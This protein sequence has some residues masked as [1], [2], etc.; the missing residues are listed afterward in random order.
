MC[1]MKEQI[2]SLIKSPTALEALY[3]QDPIAFEKAFR[4]FALDSNISPLVDF[5]M[6]RF[7]YQE[8]DAVDKHTK[9][10]L[11]NYF[12]LLFLMGAVAVGWVFLKIPDFTSINDATFMMRN[13][14]LSVLPAIAIYWIWKRGIPR[15]SI[16]SF[17][18]ISGASIAFINI[19]PESKESFSSPNPSDTFILSCICLPILLWI[20][21]GIFLREERETAIKNLSRLIPRTGELL[22]TS[23]LI[24]MGWG[25]FYGISLALFNTI[26]IDLSSLFG[27]LIIPMAV[28][29]PLIAVLLTEAY[30]QLATS[31]TSF[32]ARCFVPVVLFTFLSYFLMMF[33]GYGQNV[34]ESREFLI[35]FNISA[36]ASMAL[37]LFSLGNPKQPLPRW[38]ISVNALLCATSAL[39]T[40]AVIYFLLSRAFAGG[41][42]P[43]RMAALGVDVILGVQFIAIAYQLFSLYAR[44][45]TFATLKKAM[46]V[47][48]YFYSVWAAVV[49]FS[50]PLL[51]QFR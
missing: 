14:T 24:T 9:S 26:N 6:A 2:E 50:F 43:N 32:L 30:P 18:V 1:I 10:P 51:F 48:F 16:L 25:V 36:L 23:V 29:T 40:F 35:A 33:L 31:L 49:I 21:M 45:S 41:I 7:D 39:L 4:E 5:W 46:T 20:S 13:M 44:K 19:F 42:T 38:I 11:F 47:P 8:K 34:F 28:S 15:D 37:V 27:E 22:V 17:A 3:H 12:D